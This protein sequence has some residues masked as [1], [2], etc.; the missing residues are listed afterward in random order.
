M[1]RTHINLHNSKSKATV[2]NGSCVTGDGR[3]FPNQTD[4]IRSIK[5][6]YDGA[7]TAYQQKD[8]GLCRLLVQCTSRIAIPLT[9]KVQVLFQVLLPY[10]LTP[11]GLFYALS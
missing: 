5:D 3:I 4:Y 2:L 10:Y 7:S 1:K 6:K 9:Q 11:Q 8:F